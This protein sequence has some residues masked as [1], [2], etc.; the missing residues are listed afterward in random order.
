[1]QISTLLADPEAT[2][3]SYVRPSLSMMALVVLTDF[4]KSDVSML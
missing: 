4:G 2:R 3:L 1:M